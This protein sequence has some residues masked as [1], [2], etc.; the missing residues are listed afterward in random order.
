M[1]E[2]VIRALIEKVGYSTMSELLTSIFYH[3]FGIYRI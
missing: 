2:E 3:L 1:Q